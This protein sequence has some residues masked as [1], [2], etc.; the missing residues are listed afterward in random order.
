MLVAQ[1]S[2][3]GIVNT[4][5]HFFFTWVEKCKLHQEIL[6]NQVNYGHKMFELWSVLMECIDLYYTAAYWQADIRQ[7]FL[8]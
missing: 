2:T 8:A 6:F 1:V 3:K 5:K 4:N 7:S